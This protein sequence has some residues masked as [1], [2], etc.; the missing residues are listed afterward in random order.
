MLE[1]TRTREITTTGLVVRTLDVGESDKLLT[2]LTPSEG[3]ILVSGKGVKNIKSHRLHTSQLFCYC[4]F[5]LAAKG[6]RYYL[7][8]ASLIEDFY[9]LREDLVSL[10]LAQY[11]MEVISTVT[12]TG[13]DQ[14]EILRLSLNCLYLLT[15]KKKPQSFIKA[16]FELRLASLLGYRPNLCHCDS[17]GKKV[18]SSIFDIDGGVVFCRECQSRGKGTAENTL[19]AHLDEEIT[20]SMEY[21]CAAPEKRIFAFS[22]SDETLS[23]LS[24][25]CEKYLIEHLERS[26]DTLEFYKSICF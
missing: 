21:I 2:L 6:D 12:I 26:F 14:S 3:K 22:P 15:E 11:F 20:T 25:I 8:E 19:I 9:R 18:L 13:E 24:T 1:N 17:C 4:E 7:R 5:V 10:S 23:S 16:G